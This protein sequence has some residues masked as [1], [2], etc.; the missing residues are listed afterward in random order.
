MITAL[1]REAVFSAHVV[2]PL[3]AKRPS[4]QIRA[5]RMSNRR[6]TRLSGMMLRK[7]AP[8]ESIGAPC[9]RVTFAT[10]LIIVVLVLLAIYLVRRVP[11]PSQLSASTGRMGR[12]RGKQREETACQRLWL[13]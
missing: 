2:C 5:P 12:L 4:V 3:E 6:G 13:F 8:G 7:S 11:K 10:I 9:D 1:G